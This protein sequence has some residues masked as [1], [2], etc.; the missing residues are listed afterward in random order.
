MS[1]QMVYTRVALRAN[2]VIPVEIPEDVSL[3]RVR[4]MFVGR[5]KANDG[6][7]FRVTNDNAIVQRC[8]KCRLDYFGDS[9]DG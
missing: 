1:R 3:I 9:F 7:Q 2:R 8:V 5:R 6:E 4:T